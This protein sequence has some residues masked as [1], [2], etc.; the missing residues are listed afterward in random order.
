MRKLQSTKQSIKANTT[1]SALPDAKN[2]SKQN[3]KNISA[4]RR[5]VKI[6]VAVMESVKP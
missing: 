2:H 4:E 3:P 1:I 6:A 5:R